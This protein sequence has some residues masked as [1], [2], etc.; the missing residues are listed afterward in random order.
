MILGYPYFGK[1]PYVCNVDLTEIHGELGIGNSN[2]TDVLPWLFILFAYGDGYSL[3]PFPQR[4]AAPTSI[5]SVC[6]AYTVHDH[7]CSIIIN[8]LKYSS[9]YIH[10]I[11]KQTM[12]HH[13]F[14]SPTIFFS[15]GPPGTC[16]LQVAS[17]KKGEA[18]FIPTSPGGDSH[19]KWMNIAPSN[20]P[21]SS[22]WFAIS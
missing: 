20:I 15:K 2:S 11:L 19:G 1:P 12:K 10:I 21:F 22:Q 16:I 7:I 6:K 18:I 17:V 9:R 14:W 3:L 5:S 8:H 4:D 13:L